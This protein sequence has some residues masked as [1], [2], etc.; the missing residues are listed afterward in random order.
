M[1]KHLTDAELQAEWS[2]AAFCAGLHGLHSY[3]H[4]TATFHRFLTTESAVS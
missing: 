1:D 4:E 2:R 3:G